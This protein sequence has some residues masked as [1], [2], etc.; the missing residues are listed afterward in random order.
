MGVINLTLEGFFFQFVGSYDVF[1]KETIG[2][3][4]KKRVDADLKEVCVL[5]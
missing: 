3:T 4:V 5:G 2:L 1:M